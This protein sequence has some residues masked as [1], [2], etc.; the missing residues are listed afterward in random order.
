M[1]EREERRKEKRERSG[2]KRAGRAEGRGRDSKTDILREGAW[3]SL[4]SFYEDIAL[5]M[6]ILPYDLIRTSLS[7]KDPTSK[8]HHLGIYG[9]II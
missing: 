2:R 4:S 8:Y 6:G 7:F 5:I 9:F 3:S 1:A